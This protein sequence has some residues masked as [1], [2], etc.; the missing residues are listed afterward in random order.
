MLYLVQTLEHAFLQLCETS[1]QN[2]PKQ[3]P[4]PPD[5]TLEKSQSFGSGRDESQPIL[6]VGSAPADDGHKCSGI[7]FF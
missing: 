5:G 1:D 6:A 7:D 3:E 2:D 4:T